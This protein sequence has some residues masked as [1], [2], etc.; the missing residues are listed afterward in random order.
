[1]EFGSHVTQRRFA[2]V[3]AGRTL[4]RARRRVQMLSSDK[5]VVVTAMRT[6]QSW[7]APGLW[8]LRSI[9]SAHR[10]PKNRTPAIASDRWMA[11][12][13]GSVIK[14]AA[15]RTA[16][17]CVP[18]SIVWVH[19]SGST[20]STGST[21]S[22][23]NSDSSS[24]TA[25]EL[26]ATKAGGMLLFEV[27]SGRVIHLPRDPFA[28][29]YRRRREALAQ[30]LPVPAF[31]LTPDRAVLTEHLV[32]GIPLLE[33]ALEVKERVT[34]DL[35]GRAT[36]MVG[37]TR[38]HSIG[39]ANGDDSTDVINDALAT[40]DAATDIAPSIRALIAAQRDAL[41]AAAKT[42][43]LVASHGD[44]NGLNIVVD[45]D[46]WTLID[47]EDCGDLPYF[48]DAL[49]PVVS[50]RPLAQL[51]LRGAFDDQLTALTQAA[52]L[53]AEASHVALQLTAVA[54]V[55]AVRH[56]TRHGGSVGR[57]LARS[58]LSLSAAG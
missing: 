27:S 25:T 51:A 40:F 56:A 13:K 10:I 12:I 49:S 45:G 4:A 14:R 43:P 15:I 9:G 30:H 58:W 7:L 39:N 50:D 34:R 36:A 26:L 22:R 53:S 47:F 2:H 8:S 6:H 24:G 33:C 57:S 18:P 21:G 20:G 5:R 29:D 37:A 55:A 23:G 1:V 31:R 41:V 44:A 46:D 38:P 3:I 16:V 32:T 52:G 42:W 28:T 17:A 11:G 19:D 48:Y 54:L 35:I